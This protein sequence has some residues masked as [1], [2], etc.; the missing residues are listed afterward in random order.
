MGFLNEARH[1]FLSYQIASQQTSRLDSASHS[2]CPAPL[3][4]AGA[5][6]QSRS[7][8]VV[9]TVVVAR[10]DSDEAIQLP[11]Q[12]ALD[13]FAD[14]RNDANSPVLAARERPRFVKCRV[15]KG[16][17]GSGPKWPAR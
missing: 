12:A 11:A 2:P 3:H 5:D 10:S 13:C 14:A 16:A 6:K 17:N 9:R 4:C 8:G 1:I 15:G 7:R